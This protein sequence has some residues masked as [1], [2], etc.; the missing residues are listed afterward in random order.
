MAARATI[1]V[2]SAN[3]GSV[4]S[5][6]ATP[7]M[8]YE[9]AALDYSYLNATMVAFIDENSKNQ[10][11]YEV[12]A[13]SDVRVNLVGK[14]LADPIVTT[15]ESYTAFNKGVV[16]DAISFSELF[17]RAVSYNRS[18]SDAFTLDDASQIDKDYFGNKGNLFA[19]SDIVGLTQ[20]KGLT[21]SY[22]IG[23]VL[24][25]A[26]AFKRALTSSF[27]LG[28][29]VDTS[30]T[31][32]V[33]DAF[34]LDDSALVDKDYFG[35][36]GNI[37]GF[38][39]VLVVSAAYNK[40]YSSTFGFTEVK[41]LN[42]SKTFAD[43]INVFDDTLF[44]GGINSRTLNSNL[45]NGPA[46]A[47]TG[48]KATTLSVSALKPDDLAFLESSELSYN[49]GVSDGLGLG[50]ENTTLF[51]KVSSDPL[52]LGD[53]AD[54]N[55]SKSDTDD[56]TLSDVRSNHY[57]KTQPDGLVFSD[58]I[59]AHLNKVATDA[60]T[61]DDSALV[62]KDYYGNKGNIIGINDLVVVTRIAR[63][64]LNGAPLNRTQIN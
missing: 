51:N 22:T 2:V 35:N 36:K 61:L 20:N 63:R 32:V 37:I 6:K 28:E 12:V 9:S 64:L 33:S 15:D 14:N 19:F 34:V 57:E 38:S 52:S 40:A 21:D 1:T 24:K 59:G 49:K 42:L 7:V 53:N 3:F 58:I 18:L 41:G 39:E 47:Y 17:V 60:F 45:L 11:F 29:S 16:G 8:S 13:L 10:W 5:S 43:R 44:D 62:D 23:D 46:P 31:K 55:I 4:I 25:I 26:T 56:V 54:F 50:D 48:G 27:S 30:L